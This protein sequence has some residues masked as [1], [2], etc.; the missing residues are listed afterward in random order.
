MSILTFLDHEGARDTLEHVSLDSTPLASATLS[1]PGSLLLL[2][3]FFHYGLLKSCVSQGYAFL[4]SLLILRVSATT[5]E[6]PKL[7]LVARPPF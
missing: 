1:S 2:C 3:L 4:V 6:L 7:D 5:Y